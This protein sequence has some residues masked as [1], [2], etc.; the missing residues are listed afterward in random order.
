MNMKIGKPN[1]KMSDIMTYDE[2]LERYLVN[3]EEFVF[4]YK[5]KIIN[6]CW[7]RDGKF[8]YN[9]IENNFLIE[10]KEYNSPNELLENLEVDHIKFPDLWKILW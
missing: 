5:N 4:Y 2:F 7:G 8:E 6:L 1:V 3:H 9:I 10:E